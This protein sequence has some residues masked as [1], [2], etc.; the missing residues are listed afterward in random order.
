MKSRGI[1][2]IDVNIDGGYKEAAEFETKLEE[3]IKSLIKDDP[4]VIHYQVELRERRGDKAVD[5]GRMKFR[6]N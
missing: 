3:V 2:I 5:L 6:A 1:C 4:R